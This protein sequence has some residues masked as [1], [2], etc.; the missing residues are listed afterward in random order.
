V[1]LLPATQT[2]LES[3]IGVQAVVTFDSRWSVT[4]QEVA[5]LRGSNNYDPGTEWL[6]AQYQPDPGLKLRLGRV[7]L[8][9]FLVSDTINVGYTVPWFR[10]PNDLYYTE[11]YEYIDG[12]QV[13]WQHS[14]GALQLNLETTYG[15]T[16]GSFEFAGFEITT[17]VRQVSMSP[18]RFPGEIYWCALPRRT[19]I[20]RD[21]CL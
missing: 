10:A 7:V 8:P 3:R 21:R 4:A 16:Q 2:T 17:R 19:S 9:V 14:L 13:L 18:C 1:E 20:R 12:G 15:Q 5:K 6:F 11:P